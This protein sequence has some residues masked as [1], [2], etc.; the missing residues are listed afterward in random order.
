[1]RR[2]LDE[3]KLGASRWAFRFALVAGLLGASAAAAAASGVLGGVFD[4]AP[5]N[6]SPVSA[7]PA[8]PPPRA[9]APAPASPRAVADAVSESPP[10]AAAPAPAPAAAE[11]RGAAS[12]V[13]RVHEAAKALRHDGDAAR[14]LQLLE[15]SGKPIVGPL[16]EEALALRIEASM[17]RGGGREKRLATAYLAQYPNGRYRELAQRALAGKTR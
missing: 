12:D 3:P 14:A 16:A 4:V 13:A 2:L 8:L 10:P 17:A 7:V 11:A 1:M 9:A 5:P 6:V 15:G